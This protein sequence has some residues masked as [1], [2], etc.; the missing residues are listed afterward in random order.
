MSHRF[1]AVRQGGL[2][3]PAAGVGKYPGITVVMVSGVGVIMAASM[4]FGV[5]LIAAAN[6]PHRGP[7]DFAAEEKCRFSR[8]FFQ[9]VPGAGVPHEPEVLFDAQVAGASVEEALLGMGVGGD[10]PA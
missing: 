7:A 6:E 3:A 4:Q 9:P 8:G 5:H 10:G 1:Y 2:P